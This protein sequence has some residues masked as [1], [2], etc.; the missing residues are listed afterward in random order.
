MLRGNGA[1]QS[2][3]LQNG[4]QPANPYLQD[5]AFASHPFKV[6]MDIRP[7]VAHYQQWQKKYETF[8]RLGKS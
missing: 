8:T 4:V 5:N 3:L 7:I 6:E 1:G 2:I